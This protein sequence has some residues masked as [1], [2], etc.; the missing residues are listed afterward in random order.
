[1]APKRGGGAVLPEYMD[2]T[3]SEFS[4]MADG[5]KSENLVF[6]KNGHAAAGN[7]DMEKQVVVAS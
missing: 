3:L 6:K 4:V 5:G 2:S 1:M 7:Y